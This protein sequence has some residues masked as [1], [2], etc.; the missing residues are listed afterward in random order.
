MDNNIRE[1]LDRGVANMAWWK[2]FLK[3]SVRHL[4]Y[5]FSGH[6][7]VLINTNDRSKGTRRHGGYE[8]RFNADWVLKE[9]FEYQVK[10]GGRKIL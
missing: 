8:F 6:Y 5:N 4:P 1:R 2:Q 7:P 3:Y 10:K 9:Y